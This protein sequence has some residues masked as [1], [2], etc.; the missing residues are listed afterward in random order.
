MGPYAEPVRDRWMDN[1]IDPKVFRDDNGDLYM[2]MVRFTDGNTIW[3]RKMKNYR[4][5]DNEFLCQFASL[6]NTWE[7]MDN[8]VG[9]KIPWQILHDV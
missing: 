2:Y 4:E 7:R 6:P 3:A 8:A 1:R 5:F 9:Y